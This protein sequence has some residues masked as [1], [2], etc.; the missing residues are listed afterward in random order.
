MQSSCDLVIIGAG[1]AGL[2]AAD[3]AAK[4]G[5]R[6][7]LLEA[8]DRI[9]GRAFTDTVSL[10]TPFDHGC[11]WLHSAGIN[12]FREEADKRG[13]RYWK[14]PF[15]IRI[16]DGKRWLSDDATE[17][18]WA[19]V[20][21][22][23]NRIKAAALAGDD[24]A[25]AA[26]VDPDNPWARLFARDY[27]G[28]L[29]ASPAH[30]SAYDTGRYNN[31]QEDWPVENGYGA[32]I[33]A[34]YAH[35]PVHLNC[36]VES[37]DWNGSE[38][39]VGTANGVILCRAALVTVPISILK[40][41]RLNF[42][43]QLPDWKCHAI[44]RIEMG[45][46]EKV[47]FWLK[48]DPCPGIDMHFAMPNGPDAPD[49]AFQVKPYG[50][51]MIT[52]FAAAHFARDLFAQGEQAAIA[53]AKELL[54]DVFGADIVRDVVAA[55]AT[56]WVANPWVRGAYSVLSPGGG[57]ARAELARPIDDRLFFAGEASSPDA[58]TTAHGARQSGLDAAKAIAQA[59]AA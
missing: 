53:E 15:N 44:D 4:A 36:P 5:L 19:F 27:A 38:I 52:L 59:L 54:G 40:E 49:A 42:L 58:F 28:Y 14:M 21:A 37:I 10:P 34:T 3:A 2:A 30:S 56:Q 26:F 7:K 17:A 57:E 50:R 18:Y 8:M 22:T 33:A 39:T 9:G 48:R 13:F 51:P 35:V 41:G 16:H 20:H 1:A 29:A 47:A 45:Y 32:L 55:K 43:P 31:T 6:V 46:A 24:R 25:A 11:Q 23:F 12:P